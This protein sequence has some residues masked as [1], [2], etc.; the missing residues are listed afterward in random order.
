[1]ERFKLISAV[2]LFLIKDN[3]IL[4]SR[5]FNTGYQDGNYSVP[6][7]H[8]DGD[9]TATSAMTREALEEA[10]IKIQPEDLEVIHVMHRKSDAE[11]IDFFLIAKKWEGEIRIGEPKKC[12][13]LSWFP[14]DNLPNNVI[15]Y[16][17]SA[18]KNY[19]NRV[20]YSEF[21]W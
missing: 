17:S 21:G 10:C 12:D 14:L 5:R 6:A 4:L 11:R 16:V 9:E 15:P 1:M 18:I 13:D 3:K 19:Q 8:L 20:S 2:H 7:G